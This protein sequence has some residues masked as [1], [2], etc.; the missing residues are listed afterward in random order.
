MDGILYDAHRLAFIYMVGEAPQFPYV[1]DHDDRNGLNNKWLN[2][3]K[4]TIGQNNSNRV[5]LHPRKRLEARL[6]N[7]SEWFCSLSS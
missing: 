6:L 7:N 3:K 2:L 5:I 1:V 4:S